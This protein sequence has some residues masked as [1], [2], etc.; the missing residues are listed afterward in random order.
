MKRNALIP[1][2]LIM[3]LGIGLM[4]ALSLIGVYDSKETGGKE[5]DN[6]AQAATPEEIYQKSCFSC[7]G[8]N[9]EGAVGPELKGVDERLSVDEIK[10]VLQ[11][12]RGAMPKGLVPS[13]SLDAMAE[14]LMTLE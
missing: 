9:Y 12:G 11:N 3:V 2:L 8:S 4:V 6:I 1:Y 13:E 5:S 10:D 14:W 7:H